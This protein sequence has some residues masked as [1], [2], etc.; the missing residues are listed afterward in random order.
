MNLHI[1]LEATESIVV[2][3]IKDIGTAT[4]RI[5]QRRVAVKWNGGV[6]EF[7][8]TSMRRERLE[9]EAPPSAEESQSN[10]TSHSSATPAPAP[11]TN[12]NASSAPRCE[13]LDAGANI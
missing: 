9:F 12:R 10:P 8:F 2:H 13:R 1:Q 5:F 7:D 6:T 4:C 3:P 11:G